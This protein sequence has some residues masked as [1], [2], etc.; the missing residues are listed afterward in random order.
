MQ[1]RIAEMLAALVLKAGA[2]EHW[3]NATVSALG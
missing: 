2:V 3:S 1:G